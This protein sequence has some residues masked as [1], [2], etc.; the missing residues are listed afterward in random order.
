MD[1]VFEKASYPGAHV[2]AFN[3]LQSGRKSS[4]V[5]D[6]MGARGHDARAEVEQTS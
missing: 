3:Q 2:F 1:D 6:A 5:E 4:S